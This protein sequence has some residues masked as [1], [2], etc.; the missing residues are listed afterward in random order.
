MRTSYAVLLAV[1]AAAAAAAQ[2]PAGGEFRVNS[3]TTGVQGDAAVAFDPT[4]RFTITWTSLAQDGDLF[5]V[6]AQR[7]TPNGAPSGGEFRVNTY[8]TSTQS[9]SDVAYSR[10]GASLVVWSGPGNPGFDI[11]G[12][13]YARDGA[14][15]GGEFTVNS[16]TAGNEYRPKVAPLP[17]G[18]FVVVW[19]SDVYPGSY[20]RILAKRYDSFGLQMGAEFQVSEGATSNGMTFPAVATAPDG[21]FVVVW[22]QFGTHGSGIAARLYDAAAGPVTTPFFVQSAPSPGDSWPDVAMAGDGSFVVVWEKYFDG[23]GSGIAARAFTPSA[24]PT[25]PEF[26]V[27]A[28]TASPQ[29]VPAIAMARS[30]DFVVV[31]S[32]GVT[33]GVTTQARRFSA[34][35]APRSG[36]FV[37]NAPNPG[38]H[39]A[40]DVASDEVGNFLVTWSGPD[41]SGSGVLARRYGGLLPAALDVDPSASPVSD[42]N[43]LFEPGETVGVAPWWR[44]VN[45]SAQAFVGTIASFGGP[46]GATYLVVD[47][48]GDYGL[49]PDGSAAPCADCYTLSLSAPS[50]RPA[51]HW[52]AAAREE[53]APDA[54]GQKKIWPL[55]VGDS[56][57]DVPRANSFYRFVETL[58][59]G[60]VTGGCAPGLYCPGSPVT[61]EQ[62]AV[63]V[64]TARDGGGDPP[65]A[66]TTPVFADVPPSSAYCRWIEE[67]AR[68]GVVTGCGGGN[69]CPTSIVS[70]DQMAVFVLRTLDPAL[71]P[72]PCGTPLFA[73]VPA[74][75]PYCRWI[76]EL[77]RRGVV[78]GCGGGNYCPEQAVTREQMAV[79]ISATFG[80]RLYGP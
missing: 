5:G 37:V 31:W 56:F 8:T 68:T 73:D 50:P 46:P 33:G 26:L 72:P 21:R 51:V 19:S 20:R 7:Y 6:Y 53:I 30:G 66:C 42:G 80:L 64:V 35:G 54:Q 61:R 59:H 65:P 52:D 74:S 11:Y 34:S 25:G 63:F 45:G 22:S 58:L 38:D 40:D 17:G 48:A 16:F 79:F 41:G 47:G 69:F 9:L 36:N 28:V 78:T 57:A 43:G 49:V 55:H 44:N 24:A 27:N 15:A 76:E 1:L 67:L 71:A 77:A 13:R 14:P 62:M 32:D 75:S 23:H 12:Q 29:S 10:T 18:G 70:R 39:S 60:N 4:G 2:V 3:Y